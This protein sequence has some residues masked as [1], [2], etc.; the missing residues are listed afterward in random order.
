MRE[1][2]DPLGFVVWVVHNATSRAA[3]KSTEKFKDILFIHAAQNI[4][5]GGAILYLLLPNIF[6]QEVKS[7]TKIIT[8]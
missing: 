4:A 7:R 1:K 8:Q 3:R 5:G 6:S 2:S